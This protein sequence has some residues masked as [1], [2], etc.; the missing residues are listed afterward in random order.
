MKEGR[1]KVLHLYQYDPVV[2][3]DGVIYRLKLGLGNKE[4]ATIHQVV[5]SMGSNT[6]TAFFQAVSVDPEEEGSLGVI[7]DRN[8]RNLLASRSL[9]YGGAGVGAE[10]QLFDSIVIPIPGG[11]DVAGDMSYM[12]ATLLSAGLH[13]GVAVYYQTRK[14]Q[15]GER[16][17]LI[18]ARR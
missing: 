18:M 1:T 4:I 14:E 9:W 6:E 11:Y 5:F 13:H 2:D 8:D 17:A 7:G 12:L 15:P 10:K 3:N 16:E